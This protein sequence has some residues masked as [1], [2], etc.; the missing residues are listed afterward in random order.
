MKAIVI[1][2]SGATGMDLVRMLI[3]DSDFEQ[4][5]I[6]VRR[7]FPID[8]PKMTVNVVDFEDIAS[9]KNLIQGDVLFSLMGTTMAK[10]G[11]QKAQWRID[12]DYQYE[13]SCAAKDNGVQGICLMSAMGASS[14]SMFFY[15]RMKGKLDEDIVTLGFACTYIMRPPSLIRK[16]TDRVGERISVSILKG[17][18]NIGIMKSIAPMETKIV[19]KAMIEAIKKGEVGVHI[20]NPSQIRSLSLQSM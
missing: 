16:D 1:G 14:K 20:Y 6:F 9:W 17:L 10:A 3:A 15:S 5:E 8:S 4:I 11:S 19:A 18:T 7:P 12:Y 2:A 13:V